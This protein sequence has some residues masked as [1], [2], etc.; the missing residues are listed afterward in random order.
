MAQE[1]QNHENDE[2]DRQDQREL[3]IFDR[4]ADCR[5]AVEHGVDLDRRGNDGGDFRQHVFDLLDRVDY[6]GAGL[7]VDREQD[8]GR[9]I[10]IG[11]GE[12][13]GRSGDCGPDIADPHR[14]AVTVG[15]DHVVELVGIGDLVVGL[16]REACPRGRQRTLRGVGRRGDERAADVL[17][18]QPARGKLCRIDL[19]P[20]RRPLFA[21]ERHLSDA[22]DLR[23]LLGE[24]AVGVLVDDGERHRIGTC[25]KNEDG[26]VGGIEFPV[27]RRRCHGLR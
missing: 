12:T 15:N 20:D 14:R 7:L 24:I 23:D 18:C 6:I 2:D 4:G 22:A 10:V 26:R 16:D 3:D 19:H 5:G 8:R 27:R 21:A 11:R 9:I 13:I 17:Q 1:Q 25:R